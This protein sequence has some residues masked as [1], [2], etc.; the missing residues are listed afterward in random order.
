MYM[1]VYL[2]NSLYLQITDF[3]L[4]LPTHCQPLATT[5]M[6]F[7]SVGL[8]VFGRYVHVCRILHSTY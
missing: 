4:I 5:R 1:Y 2:Y 8:F 7:M 3:Q 6:F